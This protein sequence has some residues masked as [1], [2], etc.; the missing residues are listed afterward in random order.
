MTTPTMDCSTEAI[1][2]PLVFLFLIDHIM[3]II[4]IEQRV[5]IAMIVLM[6]VALIRVHLSEPLPWR[7]GSVGKEVSDSEVVMLL[8]NI[9]F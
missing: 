2:S 1:S 7:L 9:G 5:F 8:C 4:W 6:D 3:F